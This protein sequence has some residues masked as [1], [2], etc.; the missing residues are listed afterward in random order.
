MALSGDECY[1]YHPPILTG[2]EDGGR[3]TDFNK[4][5]LNPFR[6]LASATMAAKNRF[7]EG[8]TGSRTDPLRRV[9]LPDYGSSPFAGAPWR[10]R[11][12]AAT[13]IF[14]GVWCVVPTGSTAFASRSYEAWVSTAH[15]FGPLA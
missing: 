3:T 7:L 5:I 15:D 11:P 12:P 14:V 10:V 8:T 13:G 9:V 1:R 2:N 4:H 6:S